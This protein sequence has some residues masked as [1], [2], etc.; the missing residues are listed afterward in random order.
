MIG[1]GITM[2]TMAKS[3]KVINHFVFMVIG[4]TH[5]HKDTAYLLT[6]K[7]SRQGNMR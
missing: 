3:I 5:F 1:K 2:S 7:L 6:R 4:K